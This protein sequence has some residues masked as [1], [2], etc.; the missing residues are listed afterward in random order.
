MTDS[1]AADSI[2]V[3][4]P[5]ALGLALA[6][7]VHESGVPA[8]V[9]DHDAARAE[10]LARGGVTVSGPGDRPERKVALRVTADPR[11]LA[12]AK[13][14]LVCVKAHA[15]PEAARALAHAPRDAVLVALGNG[16]GRG[17][18]LGSLGAERVLVGTTTE[19]ATLEGEG[20]V[21]HVARGRTRLAPLAGASRRPLATAIAAWLTVK[22][23]LEAEPAPDARQLAWEKVQ[24]NAAIN[25]LAALLDVPNGALLESPSARALAQ[26]AAEECA[27]VANALGVPGDWTPDAARARWEAVARATAA[28]FCST[29]QD[30]RKRRKSE[31]HAINGAIARAARDARGT[32]LAPCAVP[33]NEHL[34]ALVAAREELFREGLLPRTP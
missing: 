32:Q 3:L 19:A 21:R 13:L 28:N 33:L 9:L 11:A 26:E 14:A 18:A 16:L 10:R 8:L 29:V 6:A 15:D 7:L 20:R 1:I 25:A 12:E 30:H 4:G 31:I 22:C 5:G 17:E 23:G 34:A 27:A 24:V 2:A